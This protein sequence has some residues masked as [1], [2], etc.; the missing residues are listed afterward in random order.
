MI[1][2][3][4]DRPDG[5]G[6][7]LR[8]LLASGGLV[9]AMA[10]GLTGAAPAGPPALIP[11]VFLSPEGPGLR[12]ND[13]SWP[14]CPR[15]DGGYA[16][17]PPPDSAQYVIIGLTAGRPFTTNP[18][19]DDQARWARTRGIP[20]QVYTIPAWPTATQLRDHGSQ[21]PWPPTSRVDRLR[22]VGYAQGEYALRTLTE[23]RLRPGIVWLDVEHLR[24]QPWRT[25][26]A[27]HR[28]ENRTVLR[29]V[30]RRLADAGVPYGFYSYAMGWQEITG[31]WR[32]P[33]VPVWATAGRTTRARAL[34]LC[35]RDSFSG[36][37][38][39]LSQWYSDVR[40]S[41]VTCPPFTMTP[42]VAV[43]PR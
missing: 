3:R 5:A 33:H 29:G 11:P 21:G 7:R 43:P 8:R 38:V 31:G 2:H 6:S 36:G 41:N 40:D 35:R 37:P 42:P 26:T 1:R 28:A 30:M 14:Q 12:G 25:R 19:L 17:P 20:T 34:A 18:C 23:H 9:V 16:L 10:T 15:N 4:P 24:R 32:L 22:N 13:I 39:L 27:T